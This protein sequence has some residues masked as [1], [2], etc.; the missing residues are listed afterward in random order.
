MEPAGLDGFAVQ[1][2]PRAAG[3]SRER[4]RT[5]GA[6]TSYQPG[7]PP[8]PCPPQ[9]T[10]TWSDGSG[11]TFAPTV[12]GTLWKASYHTAR[13]AAYLDAWLGAWAEQPGAACSR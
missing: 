6:G 8:A 7:A 1:G 5:C 4:R 11:A 13:A 10:T 12:K 3:H 2:M 9:P